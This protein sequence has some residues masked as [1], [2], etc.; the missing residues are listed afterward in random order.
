MTPDL[1]GERWRPIEDYRDLYEVSDHGRVRSLARE[2]E[3]IRE[4]Y[5]PFTRPV[6]ERILRTVFSTGSLKVSLS[7]DRTS[8]KWNVA[9]LVSAA[10]M[11]PRPAGYLVM[12]RDGDARN[13]AL[14]NL[15]FATR[16]EIREAERLRGTLPA[17]EQHRSA[18]LDQAAVACVRAN[19]DGL[20]K[21]LLAERFGVCAAQIAKVQRGEQWNTSR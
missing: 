19:P 4:G 1:P 14:A 11:R 12:C 17:G 3:V 8:I 13:V 5:P 15:V 2:T 20:S 21:S 6:E 7:R 18:K 16:A 10:F 9:T